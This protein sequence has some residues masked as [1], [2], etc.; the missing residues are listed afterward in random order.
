M[1]K[2]DVIATKIIKEQELIMG[3]VAWYEAGKVRGLKI[4]DQSTGSVSIEGN[5]DSKSVVD[6]LVYQYGNLFGRAAQEVC[7]ESVVA[8]LAE[9]TPAEVPSSLK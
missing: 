7:K 4:L 8:L 1:S 5:L 2:Y 3:P 9:L 6:D